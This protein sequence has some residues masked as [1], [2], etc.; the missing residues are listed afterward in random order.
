MR[1]PYWAFN[2]QQMNIA[3]LRVLG[4][5]EAMETTM[6][7][8]AFRAAETIKRFLESDALKDMGMRRE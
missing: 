8:E 3:L 7:E 2:E 6:R 4:N 5:P 1:Q